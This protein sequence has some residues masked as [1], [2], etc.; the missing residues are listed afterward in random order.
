MNDDDIEGAEGIF[1]ED[2]EG[3]AVYDNPDLIDES[4]ENDEGED[5]HNSDAEEVAADKLLIANEKISLANKT[6]KRKEK[7][8]KLKLVKKTKY[9]EEPNPDISSRSVESMAELIQSSEPIANI[10]ASTDDLKLL[11]SA[12]NFIDPSKSLV[13]NRCHFL[14]V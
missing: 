9:E 4:D 11:I 8:E 7:F 12:V 6:L 13:S 1:E 14:F 3:T 2:L 5:E 10:N